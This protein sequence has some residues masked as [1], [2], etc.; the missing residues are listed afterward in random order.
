MAVFSA[1]A[2]AVS[3]AAGSI[4]TIGAGI[5]ALGT[6]AGIAGQFQQAAGA[7]K[8]QNAQKRQEVL[9]MKQMELDA[10][11]K[12]RETIRQQ[13]I[14]RA[15]ALAAT[16]AQGAS[17]EGSSALAGATGTIAG[18][19]GRNIQ[20]VNSNL[21]MGRFMF[22]AKGDEA[23]GNA[24]AARGGT[25]SNIGTGMQSLGNQLVKNQETIRRI[26]GKL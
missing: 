25:V 2:T 8:A 1:I 20:E 6:V 7:R 4:G 3:A 13:Q 17:A 16:T 23:R 14:A 9:R 19:A 11:R 26:G 22:Q 10:D 12:R 18:Q 15:E 24:M 5:S 21:E